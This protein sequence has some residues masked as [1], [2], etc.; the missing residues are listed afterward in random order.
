MLG[1][2]DCQRLELI[3]SV[4]DNISEVGMRAVRGIVRGVEMRRS[5]HSAAIAL[6]KAHELHELIE[7]RKGNVNFNRAMNEENN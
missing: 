3:E 4:F 2:K 5:F 6:A 1:E 7:Q